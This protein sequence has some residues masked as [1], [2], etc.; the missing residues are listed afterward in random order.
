MSGEESSKSDEESSTYDTDE[1]EHAALFGTVGTGKTW[2]CS[3]IAAAKSGDP[4]A[5]LLM[6][7][8][9][10]MY[11]QG[12]DKCALAMRSNTAILPVGNAQDANAKN[13]VMIYDEAYFITNAALLG[14]LADEDEESGSADDSEDDEDDSEDDDDHDDGLPP[15]EQDSS[16][17]TSGVLGNYSTVAVAVEHNSRG[18]LHMHTYITFSASHHKN[19]FLRFLGQRD[20]LNPQQGELEMEH[21]D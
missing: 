15:L 9:S 14:S 7:E 4:R 2:T 17:A 10:A 1:F 3:A 19:V 8:Q 6:Y 20:A 5:A 16:E 18:A 11:E 13:P 21:V 12:W